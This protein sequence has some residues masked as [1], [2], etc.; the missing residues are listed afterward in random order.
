MMR[1][2]NALKP[3]TWEKA[4]EKLASELGA[5]KSKGQAANAVFINQHEPA[6]SRHSSTQCSSAQRHA[7]PHI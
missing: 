5:V 3:T 6:R 2:G 7:A 4:Y 1:E